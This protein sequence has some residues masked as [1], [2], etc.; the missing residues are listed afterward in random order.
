MFH[1]TNGVCE[2]GF[3]FHTGFN[4]ERGRTTPRRVGSSLHH[5]VLFIIAKQQ[6]NIFRQFYSSNGSQYQQ[7]QLA[8]CTHPPIPFTYFGSLVGWR[9]CMW[10]VFVIDVCNCMSLLICDVIYCSISL[11][12]T[13][14]SFC[15]KKSV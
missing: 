5:W 4:S 14:I 10:D 13:K 2:I 3:R 11:M 12:L 15:Q 9:Q 7:K 6:G 1:L 8:N